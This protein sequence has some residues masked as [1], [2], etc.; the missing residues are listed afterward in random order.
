ML[1]QAEDFPVLGVA[2]SK[3]SFMIFNN[4]FYQALKVNNTLTVYINS[5]S[6]RVFNLFKRY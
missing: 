1:S 4:F 6:Q 3:I 2:V 5:D